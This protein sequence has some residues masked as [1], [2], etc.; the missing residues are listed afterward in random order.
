[1]YFP[2]PSITLMEQLFTEMLNFKIW[3]RKCVFFEIPFQ[4]IFSYKGNPLRNEKS[5]RGQTSF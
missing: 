1:M 4:G 3:S 5:F 2:P